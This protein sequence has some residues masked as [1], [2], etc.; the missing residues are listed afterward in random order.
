MIPDNIK[1]IWIK[2]LETKAYYI[3]LSGAGGGGFFLGIG[4]YNGESIQLDF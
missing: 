1:P 4:N 3:K 2:G